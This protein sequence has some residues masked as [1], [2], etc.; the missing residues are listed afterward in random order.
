MIAALEAADLQKAAV[1]L[2]QAQLRTAAR[3]LL[4]DGCGHFL[5]THWSHDLINI[6]YAPICRACRPFCLQTTNQP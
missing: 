3:F 5:A 4:A 6:H 2:R 1:L